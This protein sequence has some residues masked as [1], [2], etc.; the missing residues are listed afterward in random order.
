MPALKV[1]VTGVTG[2]IGGDALAALHE[3]FPEW[4]FS[5]LVRSEE[6]GAP[7]AKA[8]PGTKLVIGTLDDFDTIAAAAA[9]ADI[10]LHTA[11]SSDHAGSAKAIAKGLH[12]GHSTDKPGYWIH[13]S[14]TGILC[15]YDMDHKRYG[16]PPLPE[17]SYD[18]LDNVDR[19][20]NLPDT[21]FHRDV[22][23]IVLAEAA[24]NPAAVKVAVVCPPTIYGVGR[25]P[26]NQR[27]RQVPALVEATL[28][29][30]FGPKLYTGKTEWDNVHVKDLSSLFALLAKA[31]A[32]PSLYGN[33]DQIWGPRAYFFAE[34]GTHVWGEVAEWAAK[35]AAIKGYL[36]KYEARNITSEEAEEIAGFQALSWGLNSKGKALRARKYLDWK[37]LCKSLDKEMTHMVDFEAERL[38]LKKGN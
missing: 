37:P 24:K 5:V 29:S 19:V 3:S 15:W 1:F 9:E 11:D 7:V 20:L 31:A 33:E 17:Q 4:Q 8:Y 32:D 10:V 22:D 27:S 18:D 26:V 38:G 14:G 13:V 23:K 6:K 25:G 34:N 36:P 12:D 30:G 21:A 28:K 2:Y 16:Q 35:E